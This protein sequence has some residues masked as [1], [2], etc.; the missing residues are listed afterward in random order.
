MPSSAHLS[1]PPL[2]FRLTKSPQYAKR[3]KAVVIPGVGLRSE[4][5]LPNSSMRWALSQPDEVLSGVEAT[6]DFSHI[7]H[8]LGTDAPIT[9]PWQGMLV[10]KDMN[11]VLEAI[12]TALDDELGV[13]FDHYFG[14]DTARWREVDLAPTVRRII[15][16]GASRFTV[17]LP[18]C[19]DQDFLDA[20]LGA[21]DAFVAHPAVSSFVPALLLPALGRISGLQ[22]GLPIRRMR[23]LLRPLFQER[24]ELLRKH[25]K[26]DPGH[27]EPLD[28]L[29]M[30]LRF[31]QEERPHELGLDMITK[32]IAVANLGSFHQTAIQT[33]NTLLSERSSYMPSAPRQLPTPPPPRPSVLPIP[34]LQAP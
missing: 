17:G 1:Y 31:A 8:A 10:K 3:G 22:V 23:T 21:V 28:H 15:A 6:A 26:Q 24:L 11:Q 32:R 27:D 20:C 16:Q 25:G 9:D 30:M 34:Y 29:Q 4:L 14:T 18:L 19:R 12:A 13:A 5:I 7:Y 33:T 2:E